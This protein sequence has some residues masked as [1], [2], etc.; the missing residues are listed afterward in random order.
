[1]SQD[2]FESTYQLLINGREKVN[3]KKL[4]KTKSVIEQVIMF[5]KFRR[6]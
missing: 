6:L 5:T 1:M 4:K 2:P 3:I